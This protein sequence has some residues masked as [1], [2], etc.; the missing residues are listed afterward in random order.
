MSQV[1]SYTTDEFES[2]L[3]VADKPVMIDFWAAWCGPCRALAPVVE[4]VAEEYADSLIVGK[5]DID[6]EPDLVV[7]YRIMSVPCVILF[8]D[9]QPVAQ[10]TGAV[11]KEELLRNFSEYL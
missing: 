3:K 9:G 5:I 6:A 10:S 2:L 7:K 1:T 11:P 4:Q 8:K